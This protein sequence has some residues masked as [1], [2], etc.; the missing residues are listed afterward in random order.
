MDRAKRLEW[1][2]LAAM[3]T[4]VTA[5]YLTMG[6]SQTMKA[7]WIED[8][9][10][11]VAPIAFLLSARYRHRQ[12]SPEFPYGYHR[13]VTIAFLA[14]SVALALFGSFI[15]L[16]SVLSLL[17]AHHP[18]I[19]TTMLFGRQIWSGWVMIGVLFLSGIP[20]FILGRMK[21]E[22]ARRLHDKTLNADADLN[23]A[24]WLLQEGSRLYKEQGN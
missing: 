6:G 16:D 10:S 19:G 7:A 4:I 1:I 24:D 3:T 20:P 17:R 23:R 5:I 11:F 13:S 9:L 12:P 22:P 21:L 15:L 2:T 18:T 8:L 14:G